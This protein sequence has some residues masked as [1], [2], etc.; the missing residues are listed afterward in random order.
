MQRLEGQLADCC[1]TAAAES[2]AA[3]EQIASLRAALLSHAEQLGLQIQGAAA[4]GAKES[5]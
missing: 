1:G 2:R 4:A 5:S 3:Q